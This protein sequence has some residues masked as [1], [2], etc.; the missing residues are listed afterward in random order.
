MSISVVNMSGLLGKD[1][2]SEDKQDKLCIVNEIK[3]T[4]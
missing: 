2:E 1:I 3:G 4:L